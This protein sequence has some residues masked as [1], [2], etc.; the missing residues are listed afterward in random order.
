MKKLLVTLSLLLG[1][2]ISVN[3]AETYTYNFTKTE[4]SSNGTKALG[5]INW[6]LDGDGGY[7]GYDT[8]NGK[9]HQFG[10]G[11]KPYTSMTLSTSEVPGTITSITINTS[12]ASG[13]NA[14]L[15]VSVAG[16]QFGSQISLTKT[17]TDYTFEGN[18]A[19]E[20]VLSYTQTS[21]KALY[22]KSISITY[23]PGDVT[24][25]LEVPTFSVATCDFVDPFELEITAS[26]GAT[27]KYGFDNQTWNT[28]SEPIMISGATTT[29]YAYATQEGYN[30][31]RVVSETYTYVD[32]S[33][34]ADY[35]LV[36]STSQLVA[37][38]KYIIASSEKF[39]K[40]MATQN[41]NNR[42]EESVTIEDN[43]LK[44]NPNSEVAVFELQ[45]GTIDGTYSFYEAEK[46]YLYAAS[47][48]SNHL[49]TET[50]QSANSSAEIAVSAEGVATIVFKGSNTRNNLKYNSTSGLFACYA[51]GQENVYLYK[52]VTGDDEAPVY[53]APVISGVENGATY[54]EDVTIKIDVPEVENFRDYS[55]VMFK[56]GMSLEGEVL[57]EGIAF[58]ITAEN[59][60]EYKI[61]TFATYEDGGVSEIVE[62]SFTMVTPIVVD[63]PKMNPA[64]VKEGRYVIAYTNQA[65]SYIMKNE[66]CADYYVAASE[67]DLTSNVLPADEYI[68]TIKATE[69]GYTIQGSDNAYLAL[70]KSGNYVNLK[71]SQEDAFAW[72]FAGTED[73]VEATGGDLAHYICFNLYKGTTPEFTARKTADSNYL[74]PVF[75]RVG[76]LPVASVTETV[77]AIV[78]YGDRYLADEYYP[79]FDFTL[80]TNSDNHLTTSAKFLADN[81]GVESVKLV[82]INGSEVELATIDNMNF[83]GVSASEF[84][85][86][87]TIEFYFELVLNGETVRTLGYQYKIGGETMT[88][89]CV[90]EV[91][92]NANTD[93]YTIDGVCVLR[94]ADSDAIKNL[95][96]G[97]YIVGGKKIIKK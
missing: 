84:A 34:F 49:K 77:P 89:I 64:D 25:T 69:D 47:S 86:G 85:K 67:Y 12:G 81:V 90:P 28:Y 87:M 48:S 30:D 70:V 20:L 4:F 44:Y 7:W 37:G 74:F 8:Q 75:Y 60:A 9:G 42:K 31:S 40:A 29:V 51:S 97:F 46:G 11:G 72:T 50:A 26:E 18:A 17:A 54:Y 1:L 14:K 43:I 33:S 27:I 2:I 71:P 96:K 39:S 78:G 66:V 16:T 10:S 15:S 92:V 6:T 52:E 56:D 80:A 3:A 53:L 79:E 21:S 55:L 32:P 41:N 13:T 38:A 82:V 45:A 91:S 62:V 58:V 68:F 57:T 19:G 95:P 23:E 83:N 35:K 88:G 59:A 36:T 24:P 61:Q 63:L 73:A 93:V 94:N 22:I 5:D 76:D 65:T